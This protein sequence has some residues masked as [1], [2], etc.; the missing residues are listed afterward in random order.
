MENLTLLVEQ[1]RRGDREAFARIVRKYQ[2]MV[3]AVTLNVAGDYAQSEDLAQETFLIAWRKLSELHEPEKLASWFYGIAKRTALHWRE[4]Q[5]QNPLRGASELND[6]EIPDNRFQA[7]QEQRKREQSLELVWSTVK[8]LPE[9]FREPL[10]LYYRYS[11]SVADIAESMGL[12]GETVRQRLFRGRKMLKAEVE[13]QVEQVLESTRPDTAFTIAV[14]ASLPMVASVSG[15]TAA[16]V[17]TAGTQAGWSVGGWSFGWMVVLWIFAPIIL[18]TGGFMGLW[19]AIKHSPTIRTRRF[20]CRSA[21]QWYLFLWG[22]MMAKLS[23]DNKYGGWDGHGGL[24]FFSFFPILIGF[25][26]WL[27]YRWRMLLEEDAGL[28]PFPTRP[29]EKTSLSRFWLR[30]WFWGTFF[31]IL[32]LSFLMLFDVLHEVAREGVGMI[33]L[34]IVSVFWMSIPI[35]FFVVV[36]NG[37]RTA[38]NEET[39]LC[40]LPKN[41]K[42]FLPKPEELTKIR[43]FLIDMIVMFFGTILPVIPLVIYAKYTLVP[44]GLAAWSLYSTMM[45][46]VATLIASH[47]AGIPGKRLD[48]YAKASFFAGIWYL[49]LIGRAW[50]CLIPVVPGVME[51][52]LPLLFCVVYFG[53]ALLCCLIPRI[54]GRFKCK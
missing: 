9:I 51:I 54:T 39:L 45:M 8:E 44:N 5:R 10:L 1:S 11:R 32:A 50:R 36:N 3:S 40:R 12:T 35:G 25:C 20:M 38:R 48:G 52:P 46:V 4:T 19:T 14:L 16:G 2:G 28:R 23:V 17:G 15:S 31:P 24:F 21:L 6:G 29:L 53:T 49:I 47:S 42:I 30:C 26:I 13:K 43:L 33:R 41:N 37:L 18:L 22:F 34:W 7:E 27:V